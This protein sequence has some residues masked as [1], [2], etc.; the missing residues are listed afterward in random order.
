MQALKQKESEDGFGIPAASGAKHGGHDLPTAA[1]PMKLAVAYASDK[2]EEFFSMSFGEL[3]YKMAEL[4]FVGNVDI[5][6]II[7]PGAMAH[8]INRIDNSPKVSAEE[9]TLN[10]KEI[11]TLMLNT[12]IWAPYRYWDCKELGVRSRSAES[13]K[14]QLRAALGNARAE[15]VLSNP[16]VRL[17]LTHPSLHK[18]GLEISDAIQNI[19]TGAVNEELAEKLNAGIQHIFA[20]YA[21]RFGHT[22]M[23]GM[24]F[25]GPVQR[26][27]VIKHHME[28]GI[29]PGEK[30]NSILNGV[31]ITPFSDVASKFTSNGFGVVLAIDQRKVLMRGK[32][33]SYFG[34]DYEERAYYMGEGEVRVAKVPKEAITAVFR[35]NEVAE[36]ALLHSGYNETEIKEEFIKLVRDSG[37]TFY[38]SGNLS[39]DDAANFYAEIGSGSIGK[40]MLARFDVTSTYSRVFMR[41]G[42][43]YNSK[44]P[45][46][47]KA[48]LVELTESSIS[49]DNL[50]VQMEENYA[51]RLYLDQVRFDKQAPKVYE[52]FPSR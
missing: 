3:L 20:G 36:H 41:L 17:I 27:Y 51:A 6:E 28:N 26:E 34:I 1:E 39:C 42:Y 37:S 24:N 52:F 4:G 32:P 40:D 19:F 2:L 14:R 44:S 45:R 13:S 16:L 30:G 8:L 9:I 18:K 5:G 35:V 12:N 23:R 47:E 7:D 22:Y 38:L 46:T 50:H 21:T 11:T 48:V 15:E 29:D 25:R 43:S 33:L 31:P 49:M 10:M